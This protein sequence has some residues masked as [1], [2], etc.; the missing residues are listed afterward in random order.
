VYGES[1]QRGVELAVKEINDSAYL[2]DGVTL[3]AVFE[4][5]GSDA[6]ASIAAFDKLVSE[7]DVAGIIGPTLSTQAFGA[8]PVATEAGIPVMGVSN[9]ATGITTMNDDPE[10]DKF[11]FRDSLPEASVIPGISRRQ[12]K[13]WA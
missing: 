7:Q 11:I 8:D 5:G 10:L 12:P 2:G 3:T 13:F 4:D 1:Q 6:E 9:T